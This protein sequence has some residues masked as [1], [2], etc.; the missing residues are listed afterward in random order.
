M[1]NL[2]INVP[3]E[4]VD[5]LNSALSEQNGGPASAANSKQIVINF[6]K[7]S[8]RDWHRSH[9]GSDADPIVITGELADPEPE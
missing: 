7:R 5:D 6:L 1:P 8:L 9:K 2:T 4:H 3:A